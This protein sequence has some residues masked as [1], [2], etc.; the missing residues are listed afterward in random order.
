MFKVAIDG[1]AGAGKSTISKIVAEKLG[2]QYI[3]TGAMYRA[4]TYKALK[5][6]LD[7][8]DE[9]SYDFLND[10]I[11]EVDGTKIYID[12][13]D[14]STEIRSVEVTTNV[15]TP[16]KIG[17]VRTWLV[18][19]Q[20]K[21]S[22]SKN[23]VMDGRDIGTVVLP[24]ADLKIYLD[25]T[26]ECRA[27][28]RMI[29]RLEKG[30]DI[31]FEETLEEIKV[32]DHKDSTR[33]ISPL[34][35][36]DDAVYVD[37][38][39]MTIDEVV[40]KIISLVNERGSVKMSNVKFFEGQEVKGIINNVT[41]DAV[42]IELE[43]ENKAV[44]YTNDLADYVEGQKL[45]DYYYEGAD[46]KALVKQVTKDKKSNNPLYILSTKL[47]S[48]KDDIKVFEELKEND[49]VIEA[50]VVN[51]TRAGADLK[52]K[53]YNNIKIF[54]PAK[55]ID[56]SEEAL[57]SLRKQTIEVLITFVDVEKFRVTVSHTAVM[58]R[59]ARI[60]KAEA[61]AAKDAAYAKLSVGET[62]KGEVVSVLDFGAIVDLGEGVTGLLHRN[63]LDHKLVRNVNDYVK[64]GDTV[65][66]QII[67][68][69]DGKLSLSKKALID[70]PWDVLK[71]QYHVGDV[72]DGLVTKVIPAGLI[73][74]L[75]DEYSGLMPRSE[76]AWLINE[77]LD[78][79][80]KE[81]ETITVKVMEIDSAK[82]RVS[83]SHRATLA[84]PW[85]DVKARRGDVITVEI[86]SVEEKGA[87]V[88]FQEVEGF[89]PVNE[90]TAQKRISRVDEVFPV[91]EK[92]EVSVTDCDT[93]RGKLVVSAK[94]LETKKE[95]DEFDRYY[96]Q[97]EKELPTNTIAD[98][99]GDAL[100]DK[101]N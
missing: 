21:I 2:Y 76:Y 38:S 74:K 7:L 96:A 92:V 3:D 88:K 56:L 9:K 86:A 94:L 44:I 97:Q 12:R 32:R 41:K 1:P 65:K 58:N 40:N 10:T 101:L 84:N 73:I 5:L 70:H 83:L 37:S 42:Y 34:K 77:R 87:K 60:A 29:E 54:L 55:N 19:Y 79:N 89:L 6:G 63:E 16:S 13:V 4:V 39:D 22:E 50:E 49:Q 43:G 36:A 100:K 24:N 72:F 35:Q 27:K 98:I 66:V 62:V 64:V 8:E 14:V 53:E 46:F 78:N 51:V 23:V 47:Y 25:A 81:G 67:K 82:K 99:L 20:R 61:K 17:V 80:V 75:T 45:R 48:A 85:G 59:K 68:K 91:G 11:L 26:P 71:E 15:S 57:Y 30:V 28:R 33:A 18:D 52:Y 31:S 69:E 93:L 95:R 90:V